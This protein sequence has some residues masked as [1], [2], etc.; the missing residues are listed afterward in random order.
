MGNLIADAG[1]IALNAKV[2]NQ[3]GLL[4]ADSVVNQNGVIELVASDALNLGADSQILARGDGSA[5][6][7]SGGNVTLKSGNVFSDSAS[8]Q[9]SVTGGDQGG[10][11]GSVE[12]S[13][14][15]ILSLASSVDAV[16]QPGWNSGSLILDPATIILGTTGGYPSRPMER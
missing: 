6:G 1:T 14:P 16:A 9:I 3:D 5:A 15:N 7:S 4:Q 11:G 8:S 10:N 13:A 2:I 12:V